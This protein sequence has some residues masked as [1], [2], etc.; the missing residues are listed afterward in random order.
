MQILKPHILNGFV[1]YSLSEK[2][3]QLINV[4]KDHD[5]QFKVLRSVLLGN[6]HL[7]CI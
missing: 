7:L 3:S 6:F 4:I 1:L 2:I 5:E